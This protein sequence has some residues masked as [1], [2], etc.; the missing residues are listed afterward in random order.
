MPRNKAR[1]RSKGSKSTSSRKAKPSR[2]GDPRT[3]RKPSPI[4]RTLRFVLAVILSG[5]VLLIGGSAAFSLAKSADNRQWAVISI[6]LFV[7]TLWITRGTFRVVRGPKRILPATD[8]A[9]GSEHGV[10][11]QEATEARPV[12]K[13]DIPPTDMDKIETRDIDTGPGTPQM[14]LRV[15]K[16][17]GKR[18]T[19][20]A[21]L[22]GPL[23]FLVLG[24]LGVMAAGYFE[25]RSPDFQTMKIGLIFFLVGMGCVLLYKPLKRRGHGIMRLG[26]DWERNVLWTDR[27]SEIDF[28][29]NANMIQEFILYQ[30]S[31]GSLFD[32]TMAIVTEGFVVSTR[33]KEWTLCAVRADATPWLLNGTEVYTKKQAKELLDKAGEI[34]DSQI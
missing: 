11:Q 5:I 14:S 1:K 27:N 31:T 15:W 17:S 20:L 8:E 3:D 19:A 32:P 7:F 21:I 24:G 12:R 23:I 16:S 4:I 13:P 30:G 29:P 26:F 22:W 25:G 2:K 34:L 10:A 9:G 18:S 33:E 28:I 6:M